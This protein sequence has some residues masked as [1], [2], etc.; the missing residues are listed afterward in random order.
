MKKKGMIIA[1]A[2][3]AV[4]AIVAAIIIFVLHNQ[5]VEKIDAAVEAVTTQVSSLVKKNDLDLLG[6]NAFYVS[7]DE[8]FWPPELSTLSKDKL[9]ETT[10]NTR[11]GEHELN[12]TQL[13]FM[14]VLLEH[15][16]Y[17]QE[18]TRAVLNEAFGRMAVAA[19]QNG[20]RYEISRKLTKPLT[21][22]K[23]SNCSYYLTTSEWLSA[24]A[25]AE[26]LS[27]KKAAA[28][29][30]GLEE[31]V[32]YAMIV[33]D[34]TAVF[35]HVIAE[36]LLSKAELLSVIEKNGKSAIVKN[37]EGSYYNARK[38]DERF[39]NIDQT[40]RVTGAATVRERVQ[41]LH[42]FYGDFMLEAHS[43]TY[44]DTVK[45]KNQ[46]I[47]QSQLNNM[48]K[49]RYNLFFNGKV[50]F[51]AIDREQINSLLNLV[52]KGTSGSTLNFSTFTTDGAPNYPVYVNG[53]YVFV[54][55]KDGVAGVGMTQQFKLVYE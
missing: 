4:T 17:R 53:E 42:Y 18:S 43:T 51:D 31:V 49:S 3:I 37:S 54:Y 40:S 32:E 6:V 45:D 44:I 22:L 16:G 30:S 35:G 25:F 26:I 15:I 23:S 28:V 5:K 20:D 55:V 46:G 7:E 36:D 24:E 34:I 2:A 41:V 21:E 47:N 12:I 14:V 19:L 13:Q 8:Y 27:D 10:L 1:A 29:A 50:L 33:E 38:D 11:I 48:G 52:T 39:L 9:F